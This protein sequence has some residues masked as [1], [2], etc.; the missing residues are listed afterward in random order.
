M[1]RISYEKIASIIDQNNITTTFGWNGTNIEVKRYLNLMDM[2]TF[3]DTVVESCFSDE[4]GNYYPEMKDFVARSCI[5]EIYANIDMPDDIAQRYDIVYQT[6]I[7]S[8]IM[9]H[10]DI[11]QFEEI[12]RAVDRRIKAKLDEM[13]SAN[14]MQAR[15]L[16][17]A[18]ETLLDT[19]KGMFD[20]VDNDTIKQIAS[21][22][23]NMS[24]NEDAVVRAVV[25]AMAKRE[26]Q[27]DSN[28]AQDS[29]AGT[30][31]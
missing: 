24:V 18:V 9:Q 15:E 19:I 5:M 20:G 26:N 12:M 25:D 7:V 30:E 6:T 10:I 13:N 17:Q 1:E 23:P 16:M 4:S 3:V 8:E 28:S 27:E 22:I 2:M 21:A 11:D 29:S 31:K 14:E